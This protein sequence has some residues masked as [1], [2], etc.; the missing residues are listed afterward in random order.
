MTDLRKAA[1]MALE[2]LESL[3]CGDTY[4]THN[5]ASALRQ[6]IEQAEKQEPV[7][8]TKTWFEDGK[9]VTQHLHPSDI[10]ASDI[11]QERGDETAKD[12]HEPIKLRRGNLLRCIETDELCTVWATS[13]SGKTLVHW[14][15]NDF[16]EYTAEQIGELFWLEPLYAA[17]PRTWSD[18]TDDALIEEVSHRGFTIRDAQVSPN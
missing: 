1:E 9:V 18:V 16:T 15:G 8:G 13:T 17:Q 4:K 7:I 11:S 10:Y 12:K 5:A 2:A 3:D 14:G 6:A